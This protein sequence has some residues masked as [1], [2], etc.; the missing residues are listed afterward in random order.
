MRTPMAVA[1]I[2]CLCSL[3]YAQEPDWARVEREYQETRQALTASRR[4]VR[5]WQ[6]NPSELW[7][8]DNRTELGIGMHGTPLEHLDR[9]QALGI[10]IVRVT[11]YWALMEPTETPGEYDEA[12]LREWDERVATFAARGME[13]LVVVHGNPPGVSWENRDASYAR[14]ARFM[15]ELAARYPSVRYWELFNEMDSGFTDLFGAEAGIPMRERG[16]YYAEMLKLAYPAIKAANPAALVL[17]GGMTDWQE[18]PRGI[19]EG[20]GASFFD[21]MNLHTYGVPVVWALVSRGAELR[22]VMAEYGD[23]ERPLWNTEFGID[24]GNVVAAWGFPHERGEEDGPAYDQVHLDQW[25]ECIQ[26]AFE[27]GLYAKVLPYQYHAMNE[28]MNET[29][30]TEEYARE[31][32]PEGHTID[33]YGFGIVRRDGLT[34][35]PTYQWL[36]EAQW[37][38]PLAAAPT[39]VVD[40]T[41][42]PAPDGT[43][44]GYPCEWHDDGS[45]AIRSVTVSR[46]APTVIPLRARTEPQSG[47]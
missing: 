32:L 11:L 16:M 14:F 38:A 43:P 35:R 13:L 25:R 28:R 17:V 2:P 44:V 7:A 36:L 21:I 19:Y 10:R 40:I 39:R 47:S 26:A 12:Y 8:Y 27:T 29:L 24:A 37:N 42:A 3:V 30:A 4:E 5:L 22:E 23:A 41:I 9:V 15:G 31:Y 34:P 1:I 6:R 46:D 18:F 33:D 20:G 45:L